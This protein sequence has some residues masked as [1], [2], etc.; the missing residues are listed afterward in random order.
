MTLLLEEAGV[1]LIDFSSPKSIPRCR[2]SSSLYV[3]ANVDFLHPSVTALPAQE[4]A[5]LLWGW[6]NICWHHWVPPSGRTAGCIQDQ[7]RI[8]LWIVLLITH[9]LPLNKPPMHTSTPGQSSLASTACYCCLPYFSA[10]TQ[11]PG[12]LA[13]HLEIRKLLH[14]SRFQDRK[15]KKTSMPWPVIFWEILA[16]VLCC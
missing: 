13:G 12:F 2:R 11:G 10:V 14:E 9:P 7:L 4:V 6:V 1:S 15:T 16:A 3:L 5:R 8:C